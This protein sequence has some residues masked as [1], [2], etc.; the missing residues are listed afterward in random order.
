MKKTFIISL[1][2]LTIFGISKTFSQETATSSENFN[3][4]QE[5]NKGIIKQSKV[6]WKKKKDLRQED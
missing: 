1:V 3:W 6:I 5:S 4:K 2:F